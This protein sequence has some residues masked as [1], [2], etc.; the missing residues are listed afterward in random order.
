MLVSICTR[1][2]SVGTQC[3]QEVLF[4]RQIVHPVVA[5]AVT[6]HALGSVHLHMAQVDDAARYYRRAME[7]YQKVETYDREPACRHRY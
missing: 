4:V 7:I 2:I 6:A 1:R 5:V 3:L